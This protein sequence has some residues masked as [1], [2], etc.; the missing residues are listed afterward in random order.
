[1]EERRRFVRLDTRLEMSFT[2][3]PS[4]V[5]RKTVSKNLSGGGL[6]LV[7]EKDIAPGT[8]LQVAMTLPDQE[9]PVNFTAQVV[10]CEPYEVIGKTQRHRAAEVGA[11][12]VDISPKDYQAILQ[13][14]I[15]KLKAPRQ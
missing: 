6:C 15:L 10:W 9:Q 5:K 13:H 2:E 14:V 3:I 11:K 8:Q 12:F 4:G 1:M 7:T